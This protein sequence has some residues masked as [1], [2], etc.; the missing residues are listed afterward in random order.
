MIR[1]VLVVVLVDDG[2]TIYYISKEQSRA[3]AA[4]AIT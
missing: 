2:D 4:P 3:A 1:M